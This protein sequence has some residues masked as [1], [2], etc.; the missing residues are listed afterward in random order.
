MAKKNLIMLHFLLHDLAWFQIFSQRSV[1]ERGDKA[2]VS[3]LLVEFVVTPAGPLHVA[4]QV[5][6]GL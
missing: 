2:H 6:Q 3:H 4:H 5:R 1:S